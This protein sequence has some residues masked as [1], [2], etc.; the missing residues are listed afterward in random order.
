MKVCFVWFVH[1][2][3]GEEERESERMQEPEPMRFCA[4]CT[5]LTIFEFRKRWNSQVL[6]I[7]S[8]AVYELLPQVCVCVCVYMYIHIH[9]YTYI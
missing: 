6:S 4:V 5:L 3:G 1:E 2:R 7:E 9:M 8:P